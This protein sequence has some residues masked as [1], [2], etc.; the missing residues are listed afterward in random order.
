MLISY[1]ERKLGKEEY[2]DVVKDGISAE[3]VNQ[4]DEEEMGCYHLAP[5]MRF[6][7]DC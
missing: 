4:G 5:V 1:R 6:S 2:S 3:I 7:C